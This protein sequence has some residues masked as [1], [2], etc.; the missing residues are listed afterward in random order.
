MK[1]QEEKI[2]WLKQYMSSCYAYDELSKDNK[3]I[4]K[5]ENIL[6]RELFNK[7][8]DEESKNLKDNYKITRNVYTDHEGC[9]YN[10]L[11]KIK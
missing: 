3:Y 5:Y 1:K 7:V 10:T 8:Y 11:E 6:G 9:T 2:D 4:S